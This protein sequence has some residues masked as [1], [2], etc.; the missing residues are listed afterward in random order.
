MPTAIE[1]WLLDTHIWIRLLNGDPLLARPVFLDGIK[2]RE[3]AGRVRIA[4]ISLWETAMLASKGRLS[5]TLPLRDWLERAQGM[6]GLSLVPLTSDIAV[7]SCSLPGSFHGDPADRLI[8][9]SCRACGATLITLDKSMLDY[10]LEGW[11]NA[12]SPLSEHP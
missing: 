8:I 10:S 7:D 4:A 11:V 6:P 9:A 5:L 12:R 2:R 1:P 3:S